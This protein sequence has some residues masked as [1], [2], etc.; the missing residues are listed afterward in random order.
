MTENDEYVKRNIGR[1]PWWVTSR[2]VED[3][4]HAPNDDELFWFVPQAPPLLV[5]ALRRGGKGHR[6]K[7]D[8]VPPDLFA[9]S[10]V[11]RAI[12]RWGRRTSRFR[13]DE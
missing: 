8:G 10:Y 3:L 7:L 11:R 5:R 9:S 12:E 13:D 2:M 1:L 6:G 4:G